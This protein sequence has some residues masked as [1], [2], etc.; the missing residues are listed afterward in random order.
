MS[1]VPRPWRASREHFNLAQAEVAECIGVAQAASA[2]TVRVKHA[3]EATL[4]KVPAA[5]GLEAEQ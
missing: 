3:R 5:P 1:E 2:Q 4:E